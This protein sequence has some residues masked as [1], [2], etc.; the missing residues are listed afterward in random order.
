MST[1]LIRKSA[2]VEQIWQAAD[3]K[4]EMSQFVWRFIKAT[5]ETEG[6]QIV[7]FDEFENRYEE[8]E[9]SIIAE[10]ALQ[11]LVYLKGDAKLSNLMTAIYT[12]Y[13]LHS[14]WTFPN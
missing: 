14:V 6:E 11:N 4:A 1:K 10:Y 7:Q 8:E 12:N 9:V 5:I 3:P 13:L 2:E